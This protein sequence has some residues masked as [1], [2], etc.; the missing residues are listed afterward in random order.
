MFLFSPIYCLGKWQ[1]FEFEDPFKYNPSNEIHGQKSVIQFS[2]QDYAKHV[3]IHFSCSPTAE[4]KLNNEVSRR[5]SNDVD[6]LRE[7]ND[8]AQSERESWED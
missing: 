3:N 5:Y 7:L 8:F 6:C 4:D 2:P 1:A